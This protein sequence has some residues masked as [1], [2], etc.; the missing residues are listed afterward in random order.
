MCSWGNQWDETE[1]KWNTLMVDLALRLSTDS[2]KSSHKNAR[3]KDTSRNVMV[4][5]KFW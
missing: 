1:K 3:K 4:T 2:G 5:R